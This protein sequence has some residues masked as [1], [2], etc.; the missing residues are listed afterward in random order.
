VAPFGPQSLSWSTPVFVV[1]LKAPSDVSPVILE[2]SMTI[3][4]PSAPR[5][6][7]DT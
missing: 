2:G 5:T 1:E 6:G 7:T 4:P 3:S